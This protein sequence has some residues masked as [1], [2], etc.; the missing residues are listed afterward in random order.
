[1]AGYPAGVP[2]ELML[3]AVAHDLVPAGGGLHRVL[4]ISPGDAREKGRIAIA[5]MP[6]QPGPASDQIV[7]YLPR[8]AT[9]RLNGPDPHGAS[10]MQVSNWG[11]D[12]SVDV[13]WRPAQFA[14][15]D[16]D[17][18]DIKRAHLQVG[19]RIEVGALSLKLSAIEPKGVDH[20]QWLRFEASIVGGRR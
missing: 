15:Q 13:E 3:Q 8:G 5:R 20:P 4:S 1:V 6:S 17:P 11:T 14:P 9:L 16:T 7:L 10:D 19:S 12:Q 18:A 2:A